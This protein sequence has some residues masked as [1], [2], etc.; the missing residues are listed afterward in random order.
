[1]SYIVNKYFFFFDVFFN[2]CA[3]GVI[4]LRKWFNVGKIG[5]KLYFYY[6]YRLLVLILWG[7]I[8]LLVRGIY[9][10]IWV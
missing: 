10:L 3:Y 6:I 5:V 9:I 2:K 8:K 7:V 4:S 1:M